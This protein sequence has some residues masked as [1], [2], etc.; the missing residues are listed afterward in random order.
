MREVESKSEERRKREGERRQ[1]ERKLAQARGPRSRLKG[2][3]GIEI[4]Y[5]WPQSEN[6]RVEGSHEQAE[7]SSKRMAKMLK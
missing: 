5:V 2:E 4:S 1:D 6:E 3:R 7:T